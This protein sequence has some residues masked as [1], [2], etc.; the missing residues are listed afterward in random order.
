ML[1]RRDVPPARAATSE[2]TAQKACREWYSAYGPSIYSYLRFHL[3]SPDEA[4]DLTADVFLRALGGFDGFDPTRG[5]PKAWLFRIAQNALRDNQRQARR[6][7]VLSLGSFRDL[8]CEAPSPEERVLWEEQVGRLLAA[9]S[10]LSSNDRQIIAL[11]YGAELPVTE[12]GEM[13]GLNSTAARTRL[14]RALARLR[15]MMMA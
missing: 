3:S 2:S 5:S 10:E 6:R 14:W 7:P 1:K 4:D 9:I 8:R 13:L 15:K 11:C 12:A